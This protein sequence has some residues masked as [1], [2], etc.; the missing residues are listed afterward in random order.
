MK[1]KLGQVG[2]GLNIVM[3]FDQPIL[4]SVWVGSDIGQNHS[5]SP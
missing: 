3:I 2:V 5:F 4:G 1:S